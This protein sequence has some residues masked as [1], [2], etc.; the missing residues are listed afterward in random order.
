M[1]PMRTGLPDALARASP[2]L[3]GLHSA[4]RVLFR[5]HSR[6]PHRGIPFAIAYNRPTTGIPVRVPRYYRL[7][8][9]RGAGSRT[10]AD[11]FGDRSAAVTPHPFV[12]CPEKQK[13][14]PEGRALACSGYVSPV[15]PEPPPVRNSTPGSPRQ[16]G[17][18]GLSSRGVGIAWRRSSSRSRF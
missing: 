5:A 15:R 12:Q 13:T 9:R 16:W 17:T 18:T 2:V 14:L 4:R 3:D 11:G 8:L 10:L 6:V 1:R 7:V